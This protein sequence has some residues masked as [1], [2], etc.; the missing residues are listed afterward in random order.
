M[1]TM[2]IVAMVREKRAGYWNMVNELPLLSLPRTEN[3]A[4]IIGPNM[5]PREKA[6]PTSAWM[7]YY[8]YNIIMVLRYW[9][10]LS[11]GIHVHT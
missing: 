2:S 3:T 4:P 11:L 9:V 7:Y 8:Y 6:T 10:L 1:R 5:N